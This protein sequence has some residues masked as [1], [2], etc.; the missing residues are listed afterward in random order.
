MWW[1][2]PLNDPREPLISTKD[3]ETFG[4]RLFFFTDS[5]APGGEPWAAF[6]C[7]KTNACP[8]RRIGVIGRLRR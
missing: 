3:S 8:G 7:A 1:G 2:A 5:F 4:D 6:H